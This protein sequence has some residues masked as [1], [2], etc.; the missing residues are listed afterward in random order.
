MSSGYFVGFNSLYLSSGLF[1][2][3]PLYLRLLIA[4]YSSYFFAQITTLYNIDIDNVPA[5][6]R[7]RGSPARRPVKRL[8]RERKSAQ[9]CFGKRLEEMDA[10]ERQE[11]KSGDSEQRPG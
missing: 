3:L 6:G 8:R 11:S 10:R 1:G 2:F 9:G 5:I 7:D 4:Q